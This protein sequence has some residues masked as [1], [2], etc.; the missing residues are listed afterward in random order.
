[1]W[2]KILTMAMVLVMVLSF[3]A[4]AE[5]TEEEVELP[6]AQEIV[7]GVIESLDE[8]RTYQFDMGMTGDIA[9]DGEEWEVEATMVMDSHGVL[10]LENR[11]MKIDMTIN[12]A[13]PGEFKT[14]T[15][16]ETYLVGDMIYMMMDVP[17]TDPAW[18]KLEMPEG[19]W[20]EMSQVESQLELLEAAQVKVIGSETIE[21]TD[22]YVLQLTPDM[23]QL[24]QL[25]MQQPKL[26]GEEVPDV[27]EEFLQEMFTSFSVKQ[28]IAKD[29]Y[30]PIKAEIDMVIDPTS[31]AMG[32]QTEGSV[33]AGIS[34][35][36]LFYNYNQPVSIVLP[37][38]AEE[39]IE[40]PTNGEE[41]ARRTEYYNVSM[42]VMAMMVDNEMF[43][44]SN[45]A[46]AFAGGVATNDMTAFP[47]STT[48]AAD[49]G[50]TGV[51]TPKAGYVLYAHD[52]IGADTTTFNTVNYVALAKTE[53]YYTCES[54]G[55]VRQFDG[56]DVTTATEYKY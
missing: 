1:M 24:W 44:L 40:M 52:L 37:P 41:E 42:A 53:Y 3:T 31:A 23:E 49:K 56:P 19:Y 9:G 5:E 46:F 11:Q 35:V 25:A 17:E 7:D 10:D 50:Y 54:D 33:P 2:K 27:A 20:G 30:F 48:T 45:P 43:T 12:V 6:S 18:M 8:I 4:C 32:L 47:D 13:M 29:T 21:G 26:P 15:G 39:A 51:G 22:C 28:W 34:M 55:T 16:I 36:L 14:E 38:E